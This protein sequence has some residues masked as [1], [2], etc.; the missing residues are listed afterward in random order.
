LKLAVGVLPILV[1]TCASGPAIPLDAVS[2][3]VQAQ[4]TTWH[5]SYFLARSQGQPIE[6]ATGR[7]IHIPIGASVTIALASGE[8]I[9]DFAMPAL[10]LHDFAAPGLPSELH[11]RASRAGRYDVRGAEI[12][13]LPHDDRS[14]GSLIIEDAD[15]Y[16]AWIRTRVRA[17]G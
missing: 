7:E 5:A 15:A 3:L 17:R 16:R 6:V 8:Y 11:F 10:G 13:G 9:A 12:C 1:A 14:R 4:R 2:V